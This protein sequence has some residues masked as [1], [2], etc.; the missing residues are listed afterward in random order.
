MQETL[1]CSWSILCVIASI[2]TLFTAKVEFHVSHFTQFIIVFTLTIYDV[3]YRRTLTE[4]ALDWCTHINGFINIFFYYKLNINPHHT[5]CLHT[6]LFCIIKTI[7]FADKA[8]FLFELLLSYLTGIASA[9]SEQWHQWYDW[10]KVYLLHTPSNLL[11]IPLH[12][13]LMHFVLL[14]IHEP[15]KLVAAPPVCAPKT[16]CVIKIGPL[17]LKYQS[18][19]IEQLPAYTFTSCT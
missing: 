1:D 15:K 2:P 11:Y 6:V 14:H 19:F 13:A 12:P 5:I 4:M 3:R 16:Y 8:D 18:Q 7:W 17:F 10:L 9:F